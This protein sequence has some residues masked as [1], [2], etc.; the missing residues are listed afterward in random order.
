MSAR[1]F[2]GLFLVFN[3]FTPYSFLF[4]S[5]YFTLLSSLFSVL[6]FYLFWIIIE[7]CMLLFIGFCFSTFSSGV[8]SLIIYF[9]VQTVASFSLFLFYIIR[10]PFF[11]SLFLVFKLSMFPFHS[12][13]L[14]VVYSFSNFGLFLVSSFHKLPSFLLLVYFP[15]FLSLS[16]FSLSSIF[17]LLFSCSLMLFTSDFRILILSSS[18]GNNSWFFFSS[19]SLHV[20]LLFFIVYCFS[21]SIVFQYVSNR[22]F[23]VSISSSL[24]SSLGLV[25][26]LVALSGFPPFP[27]F[28]FKLLVVYFMAFYVSFLYSFLFLV[29]SSFLLAGYFRFLFSFILFSFT[30]FIC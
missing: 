16:V 24:S 1:L 29:F 19:Y 5:L 20:F 6:N 7:L 22:N 4:L 11:F 9:L 3:R 26:S 13:F 12:W 21:L 15:S 30:F 2:K 28:F 14:S 18:V 17:S 10:I 8:S 27:L 25:L 23:F